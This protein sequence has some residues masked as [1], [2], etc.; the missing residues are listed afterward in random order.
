MLKLYSC[1]FSLLFISNSYAQKGLLK[2][3]DFGIN[4]TILYPITENLT[5]NYNKG[6]G[7]SVDFQYSINDEYKILANIGFLKFEGK[8]KRDIYFRYITDPIQT[9]PVNLGLRYKINRYIFTQINGGISFNAI[10]DQVLTI[11]PSIGIKLKGVTFALHINNWLHNEIYSS[12]GFS[13][14]F[15][16][17]R[18]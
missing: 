1:I 11:S 3:F 6:I 18:N 9:I 16:T 5:N 14:G 13:V 17:S 4:A 8:E 15:L 2:A 10:E 12:C 7:G